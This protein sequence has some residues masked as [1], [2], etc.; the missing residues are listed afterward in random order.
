M[1]LAGACFFGLIGAIIILR[2]ITGFPKLILA[3]D[4]LTQRAWLEAKHFAWSRL[5]DVAVGP[6]FLS[7]GS[8]SFMDHETGVKRWIWNLTDVPSDTLC[9]ELSVWRD[10]YGGAKEEP[11]ATTRLGGGAA[12]SAIMVS[13]KQRF[14]E[15]YRRLADD[16][17]ARAALENT[18]DLVIEAREALTEELQRRRL[19]DLSEYKKTLAESAALSAPARQMEITAEMSMRLREWSLVFLA[20]MVAMFLPVALVANPHQ[21]EAWG[22][23]LIMG[24]LIAFSCYLGIKARREGSP[25][26]YFLKFKLPLILLGISTILTLLIPFLFR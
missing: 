11:L 26:E 13:E 21:S 17:L 2:Q 14:V 19:T 22:P 10:K 3:P 25:R 7:M 16:E 23:A 15:Y 1:G 5:G 24:S 20:W 9:R 8:I 12:G 18:S 4:G 6:A